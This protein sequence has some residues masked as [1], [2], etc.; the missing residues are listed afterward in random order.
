MY[1]VV[2]HSVS[3]ILYFSHVHKFCTGDFPTVGQM[4]AYLWMSH[5]DIRSIVQFCTWPH[6][7]TNPAVSVLLYEKSYLHVWGC[8]ASMNTPR[9]EQALC[10]AAENPLARRFLNWNST[11]SCKDLWSDSWAQ[12][13]RFYRVW[14][15]KLEWGLWCFHTILGLFFDES[16]LC[17]TYTS[18]SYTSLTLGRNHLAAFK[19][20]AHFVRILKFREA[21]V[22]FVWSSNIG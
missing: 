16:Y 18:C 15:L 7:F 9:E 3:F 22:R 2:V 12:V 14:K 11:V 4:K 13:D 17:L 21:S 10:F 6:I 19:Y 1:S 5:L 8:P 20:S